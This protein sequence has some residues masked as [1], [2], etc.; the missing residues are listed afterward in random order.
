MSQQ[1]EILCSPL[2]IE[3][4]VCLS[5]RCTSRTPTYSIVAD[6]YKCYR[7]LI[8]DFPGMLLACPRPSQHSVLMVS[9]CRP[10]NCDAFNSQVVPRSLVSSSQLTSACVKLGLNVTTCIQHPLTRHILEECI[11]VTF[12]ASL[13]P[14]WVQVI[15]PLSGH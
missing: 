1:F 11:E 4:L 6:T 14:S 10:S 9:L 15:S 13:T 5:Y 3:G 8:K 12:K 7:Q 2:G